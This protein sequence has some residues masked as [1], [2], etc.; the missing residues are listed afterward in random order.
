MAM[1]LRWHSLNSGTYAVAAWNALALSF[2]PG[3]LSP[4]HPPAGWIASTIL[5]DAPLDPVSSGKCEEP[6]PAARAGSPAQPAG[7]L[8]SSGNE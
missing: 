2:L 6:R 4:R 5:K 7:R 1:S 3:F 8:A